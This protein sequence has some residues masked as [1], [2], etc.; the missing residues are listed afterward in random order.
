MIRGMALGSAVDD[1]MGFAV[2]SERFEFTC[3]AYIFAI[4]CLLAMR[5]T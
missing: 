4:N 5:I 2:V 3:I 1:E